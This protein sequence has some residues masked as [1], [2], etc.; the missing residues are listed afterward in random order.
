MRPGVKCEWPSLE[1]AVFGSGLQCLWSKRA[2]TPSAQ[3]VRC[4][5]IVMSQDFSPSLFRSFFS[6]NDSL[7]FR[8]L[9]SV[10][11]NGVPVVC[12]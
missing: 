8:S 12:H 5:Q 10:Y 6:L 4:Q 9:A 3:G 7:Y 2:L 11:F 1:Y